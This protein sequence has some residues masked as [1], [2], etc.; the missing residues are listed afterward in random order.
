M[1]RRSGWRSLNRLL[2]DPTRACYALG[3]IAP[4]AGVSYFN[5]TFRQ[6][7]GDTPTGIRPERDTTEVGRAPDMGEL[8]AEVTSAPLLGLAPPLCPSK[9]TRFSLNEAPTHQRPALLREYF[10][11]T[12]FAYNVDLMPDV[13]FEVDLMMQTVPGVR[14][15]WGKLNGAR[16]R[17]TRAMVKHSNDDIGLLVNLSGRH[18]IM[19]DDDEMV[20]EEGEAALTS[21]A[22]P[23]GFTHWPT[24]EV[25][26]LRFPRARLAPRVTGALDDGPRRIASH[27]PAL[28]L[29][30]GYLAKACKTA[31]AGLHPLVATH[32]YDL[33]A[34]MIGAARDTAHSAQDRGLRAAR[35]HAIKQHIAENLDQPDLS[36]MTLA[37]R[38]GCTPRF[39]QRLF[40]TEGTTF[41]EYV[42]KQHLARAMR[43]LTDPRRVHDKISTIALDAGFADLSYFNRTFR[44]HYGAVPS[45]IREQARKVRRTLI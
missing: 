27:T 6:R 19:R 30:T 18:M 11:R 37:R 17:R 1:C 7:Y 23:G 4:I 42:L 10:A 8:I 21:C 45:D 32:V 20:L 34:V 16:N 31:D 12:G 40:E 24:G 5:C 28:R 39:V 38:H 15:T 26:T 44:R 36:V 13:P 9:P 29:L 25:L 2:T 14:F 43:L 3:R 33:V 22:D 35:L 41:T